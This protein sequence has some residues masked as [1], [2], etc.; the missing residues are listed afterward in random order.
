MAEQVKE[1]VH[2]VRPKVLANILREAVASDGVQM[3]MLMQGDGSL[4]ALAAEDRDMANKVAAIVSSIW[5]S[6]EKVAV[7]PLECVLVDNEECRFAVQGVDSTGEALLCLVAQHSMPIGLLKATINALAEHL[8]DP[9]S[10]LAEASLLS[11]NN[12]Q[13]R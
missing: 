13:P 12:S 3:S 8:H 10:V 6:Y 7:E 1:P 2:G 9:V 11:R 4:I 5:S